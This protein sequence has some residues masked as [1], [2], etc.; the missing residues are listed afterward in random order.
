[1]G[2][3]KTLVAIVRWAAL[4]GRLKLEAQQKSG[5]GT[6]WMRTRLG[7]GRAWGSSR[8]W[9][10]DPLEAKWM[11][12]RAEGPWG[13]EVFRTRLRTLPGERRVE[14]PTREVVRVQGRC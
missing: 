11:C 8:G 10:K 13:R 5:Q 4:R 12:Y 6:G 7:Q 3:R 2:F 1:M 14:L 9:G